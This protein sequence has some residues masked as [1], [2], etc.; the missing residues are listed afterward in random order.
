MLANC[1][2]PADGDAAFA[3]MRIGG[4]LAPFLQPGEL[5]PVWSKVETLPCAQA[6]TGAQ[7]DWLELMKAIGRRDALGMS[8]YSSRLFASH[9]DRT[10]LRRRYL[11]GN[12]AAGHPNIARELWE[13]Q[14]ARALE[15]N[16]PSLMLRILAAH[17]GVAG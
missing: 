4:L 2:R 7:R 10:A 1:A 9:E 5:G 13:N 12:I 14:A 11:L 6:L 3:L 8:E 16:A 15:G 17:A